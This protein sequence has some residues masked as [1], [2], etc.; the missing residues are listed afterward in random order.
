MSLILLLFTGCPGPPVPLGLP[1]Q[2]PQ[3][4]CGE[5]YICYKH[6]CI[7]RRNLPKKEKAKEIFAEKAQSI[8][9]IHRKEN[10]QSEE[11]SSH[12]E[13]G[14]REEF[15]KDEFLRDAGGG[16]E[17]IVEREPVDKVPSQCPVGSNQAGI[18]ID[19]IEGTGSVRPIDVSVVQGESIPMAQRA[20]RRF[21]DVWQLSGKGLD[22]LQ[23]AELVLIRSF[24]G[25]ITHPKSYTE[26]DGLKLEKSGNSRMKMLRLPKNLI[27]G[28]FCLYGVLA[29]GHVALAKVYVLQGE[30]GDSTLNPKVAALLQK[31]AKYLKVDDKGNIEIHKLRIEE[32]RVSAYNFS[33]EDGKVLVSGANLHVV[34]GSQATNIVNG[35]GNIIIG[36]NEKRV[37][38]PQSAVGSHNLVLGTRNEYTSYGSIV[39]GNYN[40]VSKPHAA[41]ITGQHNEATGQFS[42][43][44]GGGGKE[45]LELSGKKYTFE[46]NKATADFS[47]IIG[48]VENSNDGRN[49]IIVGGGKN[50]ISSSSTQPYAGVVN[51]LIGGTNNLMYGTASLMCGGDANNSY[52]LQSIM[53]GG[54]SNTIGKRPTTNQP[55][56]LGRY[57]M[58]IGGTSNKVYGMGSIIMGGT[59]N[60][61][62]DESDIDAGALACVISGRYNKAI[63]LNST[64]IGGDNNVA[65]TQ[66]SRRFG[67]LACVL[68]GQNNQA[69]GAYSTIVGGLKNV[70]G[71]ASDHHVGSLT[72]IAGGQ[73]NRTIAAISVIS[74]GSNNLTGDLSKPTKG[75]CSSISGGSFNETKAQFSSISGGLK[76][77]ISGDWGHIG[78]GK[79]RNISRD[80]SLY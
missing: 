13:A 19:K 10:E 18:V 21:R 12:E 64:V 15:V 24:Q 3:D 39:S 74:G 51:T 50:A 27:A 38:N 62:G 42:V 48:G 53:I 63:G 41:V 36:Y 58:T 75:A 28:I 32:K 40:T 44:V 46:G 22:R 80:Y 17:V 66:K 4:D 8:E 78:G 30:K 14:N 73:E 56:I 7:D 54:W 70:T 59:H 47:V 23:G 60:V 25:K 71:D 5:G 9:E 55:K 20:S 49:S 33:S 16:E 43:I 57:A 35:K 68:G 31:F 72:C 1:C 26:Q 37:N 11:K 65:G 2:G 67:A 29:S 34:N 76:N 6:H 61:A 52:G 77:V 79:K 69:L 45:T